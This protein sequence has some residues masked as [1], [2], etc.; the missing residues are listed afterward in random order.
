MSIRWIR[1]RPYFI[2]SLLLTS[3][4]YLYCCDFNPEIPSEPSWPLYQPEYTYY[5]GGQDAGETL[6]SV[7]SSDEKNKNTV[8]MVIASKKHDNVTWLHAHLPDWKKNI[9]VV[10]DSDAELT[11]PK[12]KGKEAMVFLTYIIDHYYSL[13]ENIVF[14]QA[15][16]F[17]WHNDDP[18]YDALTLLQRFRFGYL[19]EQGYANLRCDWSLGCP[20]SIR[21]FVDA[22][23]LMPGDSISSKHVYKKSFEQLFPHQSV[24][25]TVAVACCSQFAVRREIIRRRSRAE[26][27]RYR[28]WL[29]DTDLDDELSGRVF[30]YAWHSKS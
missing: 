23:V 14:H 15:Q 6:L 25:E 21:P 22:I 20:S 3:V 8:E 26:Y 11:I 27:I 17:Q 12:N 5:D 2:I 10:D 9:Y 19:E 16:R 24:P 28:K 18:D 4:L 1:R 29:L 7:F 13:P 30:E